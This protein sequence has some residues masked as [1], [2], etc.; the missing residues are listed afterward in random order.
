MLT[1]ALSIRQQQRGKSHPAIAES[2]LRQA[3]LC[4]AQKRCTE[5]LALNRETLAI[6]HHIYPQPPLSQ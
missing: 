1:E 2:M 6:T 3:A 5:A 4:I